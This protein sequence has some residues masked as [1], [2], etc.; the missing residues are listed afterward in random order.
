MDSPGLNERPVKTESN[1]GIK[2]HKK[3]KHLRGQFS[4][5]RRE[6]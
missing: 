6:Q 3:I 2:A 4:K 5:T 1:K